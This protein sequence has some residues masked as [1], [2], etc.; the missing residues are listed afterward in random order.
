MPE[1]KIDLQKLDQ[2]EQQD[3]ET[4]KQIMTQIF[5]AYNVKIEMT[6]MPRFYHY[7][8][9]MVAKK[10]NEVKKKYTLEIKQNN[11]IGELDY[12]PIRCKKYANIIQN[13]K[14]DETPLAIYLCANGTYYVFD[15]KK[16]DLNK[17]IVKNWNIA[18]VQY[19]N[20]QTYEVKP[21]FFMPITEAQYTGTYAHNQ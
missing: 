19:T 8:A 6:Q 12:L 5:N 10:G 18:K 20:T 9:T 1:G 15:L 7:D 13:T 4:T 3:F 11:F 16:L 21:T 14:K 2:Q 17:V